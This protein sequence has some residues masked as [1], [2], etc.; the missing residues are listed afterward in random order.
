MCVN[1]GLLWHVRFVYRCTPMHLLALW[2]TTVRVPCLCHINAGC[3]LRL[4]VFLVYLKII[5][6][7]SESVIPWKRL[8][9]KYQWIA[10]WIAAFLFL[11]ENGSFF[12][13]KSISE[14][15][16]NKVWAKRRGRKLGLEKKLQ[17]GICL[18]H[19]T[20]QLHQKRITA[21]Q[22]CRGHILVQ[23]GFGTNKIRVW[24]P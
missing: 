2:Q 18:L 10:F 22:N 15:K 24:N 20:F 13:D 16:G 14:E 17:S 19:L 5:W 4:F 21:R 11:Y 8:A 7:Q 6:P 1:V 3:M 23:T 12:Y 9:M